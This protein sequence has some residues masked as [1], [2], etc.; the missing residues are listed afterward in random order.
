[1]LNQEKALSETAV[2]RHHFLNA[3]QTETK[4]EKKADE[5]NREHKQ[6]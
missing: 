6:N 3:I 5:K 2:M 4:K 1:M